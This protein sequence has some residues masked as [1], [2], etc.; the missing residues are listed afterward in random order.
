MWRMTLRTP[1]CGHRVWLPFFLAAALLVGCG[2]SS[3]AESGGDDAGLDVAQSDDAAEAQQDAAQDPV[4]EPVDL[5]DGTPTRQACTDSFGHGLTETFG[6]LD[7]YLVSIVAP[8]SQHSCNADSDHVHLQILMKGAVYDVAVNVADSTSSSTPVKFTEA[9]APG[10]NG[11]WE[12][13]WHGTNVTFD[14]VSDLHV[15]SPSFGPV[16]LT[17]LAQKIETALAEAN[18]ISVYATAYGSDGVH[19]VH[20]NRTNEDGAVVVRPL[21]AAPH[22]LAF[23][24]ADQGF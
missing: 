13:G 19:L 4:A 16:P 3:S 10:L 21:S 20:R 15:H 14:Y 2:S 9:D 24:F 6:R 18:H 5:P 7:G 12:E 23:C 11:Q 1:A 8:G 22:V 17:E